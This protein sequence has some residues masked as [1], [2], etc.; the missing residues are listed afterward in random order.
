MKTLKITLLLAVSA[1]LAAYDAGEA[2]DSRRLDEAIRA[3]ECQW[4][5]L[6]P[7]VQ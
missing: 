6:D 1:A 4:V 3:F 7:P 5:H 2:F